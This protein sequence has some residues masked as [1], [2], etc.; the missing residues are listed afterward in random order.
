MR[1]RIDMLC[2][3]SPPLCA[4]QLCN[5]LSPHGYSNEPIDVS[6]ITMRSLVASYLLYAPLIPL[7]SVAT[8]TSNSVIWSGVRYTVTGGRISSVHRKDANGNWYT[9][10][11]EVSLEKSLKETAQRRLQLDGL[12]R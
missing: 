1:A 9:Q 4:R 8:L 5:T 2:D 12:V 3:R 7:A 6:H 10:P 11:R